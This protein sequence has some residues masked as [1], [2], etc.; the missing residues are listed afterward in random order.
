MLKQS[1]T[2]V[3]QRTIGQAKAYFAASRRVRMWATIAQ[4]RTSYLS[5]FGANASRDALYE[6]ISAVNHPGIG[7]GYRYFTAIWFV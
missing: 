5:L 4:F 1:A 2:S 3:T 6:S 7:D